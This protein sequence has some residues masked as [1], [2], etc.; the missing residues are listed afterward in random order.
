MS[1]HTPGPWKAHFEEAYYV[2]GPDRG[3]YANHARAVIAKATG[4]TP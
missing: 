3:R 1:K 4:V 2:T